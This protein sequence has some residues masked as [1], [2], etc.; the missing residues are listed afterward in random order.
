MPDTHSENQ[1][2]HWHAAGGA[3]TVALEL[4]KAVR[5]IDIRERTVSIASAD[6]QCYIDFRR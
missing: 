5:I 1:Q 2:Q 4:E 6:C 3:A